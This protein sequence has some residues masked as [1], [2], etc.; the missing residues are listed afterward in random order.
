MLKSS[1]IIRCLVAVNDDGDNVNYSVWGERVT[2]W[3]NLSHSAFGNKQEVPGS[4]LRHDGM[5]TCGFI[6]FLGVLQYAF[7]KSLSQHL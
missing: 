6:L 5:T 7:Y 3:F 2:E 4:I 1:G